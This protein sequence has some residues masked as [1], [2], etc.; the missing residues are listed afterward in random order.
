MTYIRKNY[1]GYKRLNLLIAKGFGELKVSEKERA[2]R[3]IK[4][5][6]ADE[7]TLIFIEA[8]ELEVNIQELLTQGDEFL[9]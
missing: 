1:Y 3:V 6:D 8:T 5:E 9:S 2:E 4:T 7:I